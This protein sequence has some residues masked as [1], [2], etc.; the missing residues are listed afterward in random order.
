LLPPFIITEADAI[1]A[2]GRLDAALGAVGA[3]A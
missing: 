1:D 2:L 3:Q